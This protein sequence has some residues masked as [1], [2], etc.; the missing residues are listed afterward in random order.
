[1]RELLG[2]KG[3][4]VIPECRDCK[5]PLC[6]LECLHQAGLVVNISGYNVNAL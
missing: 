2:E 6:S 4:D 1:M 5:D 3:A